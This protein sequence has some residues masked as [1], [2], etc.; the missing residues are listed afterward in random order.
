MN[1]NEILDMIGDARGSYVWDAQ[2][3][4]SGNRIRTGRSLPIKKMW[5]IAAIIAMLL[6]LAGCAVVYVLS[7]QDLKIGENT[8][9]EEE[10]YGPNWVVIKE[11]EITRDIIFLQGL[12]DSPNQ[13]A[14]REWRDYLNSYEIDISA[15]SSEEHQAIPDNYISYGCYT[16]DMM[17]K[18]DEISDKYGLNLL[19]NRTYI[20]RDDLEIMFDALK[21]SG[22][23]VEKEYAHTEYGSGHFCPEG[24]FGLCVNISLSDEVFD[25]PYLVMADFYYSRLGYFDDISIAVCE[26]DS[27]QEWEY[28]L[29]DGSK[30][31]LALSK[32]DA[33]ILVERENAFLSVHFDS[34]RGVD[35]M[36]PE[37]V[38]KIADLFD[39]SVSPQSLSEAEQAEHNAKFESMKE[40][41]YQE[42][43]RSQAEYEDSLKKEGYIEWIE[44]TLESSYYD[45]VDLMYAFADIDGN[46][47]NDLL[48]G[49][50]GYCTAIYWEVDGNTQQFANAATILYL[51]ENQTICYVLMPGE[52]NYF[53]TKVDN[54]TSQGVAH[55]DYIPGH[56]EGEYRKYSMEVWNAYDNITK[57]EFDNIMNSYVRVPLTFLPLT[58]YP[59]KEEVV[60]Q[61]KDYVA[62]SEQYETYSEMIRVRL[63][64]KEER[65]PRWAYDIRD[66]NGDGTEEM[67]WREDDRCYVYTICDGQVAS[68]KMVSDGS[69]TPCEDGIVE[70]VYHYGPVNRTYRY[71]RLEENRAVLV[72][73]LRYDVDA[74]PKNP[75]FRSPDLTGQ[76]ITLEAISEAEAMS[77]L[78]SYEPLEMDM[79]PIAEYPFA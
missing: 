9:V 2:Q 4:R 31:L 58:D 60:Y 15:V 3:V 5:L 39:F 77:I 62:Y 75:W 53:F 7:L 45:P 72:E 40:Q 17:N 41:K 34:H 79:K 35:Y 66:L 32:E 70:A 30:A 49:R 57:E 1:A 65:W 27:F 52:T 50:D 18:L 43:L 73:Y 63:T 13:L 24:T 16:Q 26:L 54:G 37:M 8:V 14:T 69:I 61:Y 22:V 76:D 38:E 64:D 29:A 10:H 28:I 67:V 25:W 74:D 56:P 47:V 55:V 48:I 6:M 71:Y 78:A 68:Y 42:I 11:T 44:E 19:G 46:G 51:C 33:L 20:D 21:I 23:C 59:L 12:S 36:T